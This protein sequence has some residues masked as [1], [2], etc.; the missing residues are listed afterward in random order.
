MFFF[1]A[2]VVLAQTTLMQMCV[3]RFCS[4]TAPTF[5][6]FFLSVDPLSDRCCEDRA[7]ELLARTVVPTSPCREVSS[8]RV[9]RLSLHNAVH[10]TRT[11]APLKGWF[12]TQ[13][14]Q[15]DRALNLS[16]L[17]SGTAQ[18]IRVVQCPLVLLNVARDVPGQWHWSYSSVDQNRALGE[19]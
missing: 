14:F 15:T 13:H 12:R 11:T 2:R 19:V 8:P 18:Y 16:T 17:N 6:R 4:V 3:P 10:A 7:W 5:C 9:E 1:T